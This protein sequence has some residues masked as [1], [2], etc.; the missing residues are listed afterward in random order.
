[1]SNMLCDGIAAQQDFNREWSKSFALYFTPRH[2]GWN[3]PVW[4]IPYR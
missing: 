2:P 3:A 1:M 4:H